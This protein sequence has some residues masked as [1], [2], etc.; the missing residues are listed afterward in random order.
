MGPVFCYNTIE[1]G[2]QSQ[3]VY[4]T[5]PLCVPVIQGAHK[6]VQTAEIL[7]AGG[8]NLHQHIHALIKKIWDQEVIPSDFRDALI[9]I[10]FK[11]KKVTKQTA[12]T[13]GEYHICP[14]QGR[15]L[16]ASFL[17]DSSLYQKR[18]S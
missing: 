9:V 11:K 16:L 15:S 14:L 8:A 1:L 17:R 12:G 7:K 5:C 2:P 10:L 6:R 18:S 4:C 13:T 3:S